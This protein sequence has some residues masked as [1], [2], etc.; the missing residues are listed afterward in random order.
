MRDLTTCLN[1]PLDIIAEYFTV[2]RSTAEWAEVTC[3]FH[4]DSRASAAVH[5]S[6][7]LFTCQGCQR[8]LKWVEALSALKQPWE[9]NLLVDAYVYRDLYKH[10]VA[11]VLRTFP[12]GFYQYEV[13]KDG[14]IK[15][16][17][18]IN[19]KTIPIFAYPEVIRGPDPV[20]LVEGEKD[21]NSLR[22]KG[23][24]ATT[25]LGGA[26]SFGELSAQCLKTR[27]VWALPDRDAAG[28]AWLAAV[29][30]KIEIERIIELPEGYKDATHFFNK[31]RE[32]N[33]LQALAR[34]YTKVD[35]DVP[36]VTGA[37]LAARMR[38]EPI[39]PPLCSG[40][41]FFDDV[42]FFREQ[43]IAIIAARPGIGKTSVSAQLVSH[44]IERYRC[45]IVPLEEGNEVFNARV[46]VHRGVI[47]NLETILPENI[48]MPVMNNLI[49]MDRPTANIYDLKKK[50]MELIPLTNPQIVVVDHLQEVWAGGGGGHFAMNTVL[51]ILHEIKRHF[52]VT[53]LL[54][55]QLKRPSKE[56]KAD[57][58]MEDLRESGRIEE[59]GHSIAFLSRPEEGIV[60]VKVLKNR[61]G[62]SNIYEDFKWNE[63][64]LGIEPLPE[65]PATPEPSPEEP[66]FYVQ[67]NN[68]DR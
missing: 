35:T 17:A 1:D 53:L 23:I 2:N 66:N 37:S 14:T 4:N 63:A 19:P 57:G 8:K 26:N 50:L 54:L 40:M 45:L 62:K 24:N 10:P 46:Y 52:K 56:T 3:P 65:E 34:P 36:Y 55:A 12:K 39:L 49:Y 44:F 9:K 42:K 15:S 67:F 11:V 18:K 29:T 13:E 33:E 7:G 38:R 58:S 20:W 51:Q 59:V 31:G 27:R 64:T 43:G 30:K 16:K 68:S 21:A 22:A 32:L 61:Y 47:P 41:E 5:L 28:E 60:R 25:N 48:D 6:L